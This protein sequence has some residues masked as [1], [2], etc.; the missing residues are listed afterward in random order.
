MNQKDTSQSKELKKMKSG[1]FIYLGVIVLFFII[2]AILFFFSTNFIVNN[3]N[4]IFQ[5]QKITTTESLNMIN[6][7]IVEKKLDLPINMPRD[8]KII[9]IPAEIPIVPNIIISPIETATPAKIVLDKKSIN[10]NILNGSKKA[11]VASVL[12]KNLENAGFSKATTGDNPTVYPITTILI[13]DSKKE[14]TASIQTVI[15]KSYPNAIT[16][17]NPETSNFDAV[18]ITGK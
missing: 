1:D 4:K 5:P 8:N 16:K 11:G 2:T 7:L 6:Y 15:K 10:I 18:I 17:I 14:Y 13:K 9:D 12:S 3:I